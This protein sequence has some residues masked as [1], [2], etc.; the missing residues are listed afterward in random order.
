ML[1]RSLT[2][3][4]GSIRADM[5]KPDAIA[6]QPKRFTML[7]RMAWQSVVAGSARINMMKEEIDTL[8]SILRG[9]AEKSRDTTE[10]FPNRFEFYLWGWGS[11]PN[12]VFLVFEQTKRSSRLSVGLGSPNY[13][14]AV[15]VCDWNFQASQLTASQ[16]VMLHCKLQEVLDK[17]I[18]TYPIFP[19]LEFIAKHA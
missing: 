19:D 1:K 18:D 14:G 4:I 3:P 10:G 13:T 2:E 8:L 16:T 6:S 12:K 9:L 7:G 11:E 15:E 17:F 5:P